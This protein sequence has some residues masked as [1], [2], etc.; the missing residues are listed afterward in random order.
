MSDICFLAQGTGSYFRF[1]IPYA[2]FALFHHPGACVEMIVDRPLLFS[3]T[4]KKELK[5]LRNTFGDASIIVRKNNHSNRNVHVGTYRFLHLPNTK[6]KYTYI[7][8]VDIVIL[9]NI[10]PFHE[11]ML[12]KY[13]LPYSN[14]VRKGQK[15]LTGLHFVNTQRYYSQR[16]R[17]AANASLRP[18]VLDE[19]ILFDMCKRLHGIIPTKNPA[20]RPAHGIHMSPKR[21]MNKQMKLS[22]RPQQVKYM[23]H[24]V[25]NEPLFVKMMNISPETKSLVRNIRKQFEL[26]QASK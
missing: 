17:M 3:N 5:V 24:L 22:I 14:I 25:K 15:R 20:E 12:A 16:F 4:H 10:I 7:G 9:E 23:N 1:L 21:G 26:L 13:G 8:D 11:G 18:R 6:K 19:F 2:L